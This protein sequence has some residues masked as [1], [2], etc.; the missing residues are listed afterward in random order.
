MTFANFSFP[1]RPFQLLLGFPTFLNLALLNLSFPRRPIHFRLRFPFRF[2][3]TPI[4]LTFS[5]SRPPFRIT[6]LLL[7]L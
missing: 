4:C 1:S 5:F 6:R 2:F 3:C 7:C